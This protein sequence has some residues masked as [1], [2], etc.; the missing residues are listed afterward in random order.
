MCRSLILKGVIF[1]LYHII[2]FIIFWVLFF[3]QKVLYGYILDNF[4]M[5]FRNDKSIYIPLVSFIICFVISIKFFNYYSLKNSVDDEIKE[6]EKEER[7]TNNPVNKHS[8]YYKFKIFFKW[9]LIVAI[10]L[11]VLIFLFVKSNLNEIKDLNKNVRETVIKNEINK[12]SIN[13]E[14]IK[15]KF[16]QKTTGNF[17]M[18]FD[19][20]SISKENGKLTY[21]VLTDFENN[22]KKGT[23]SILS[24]EEI[25]CNS[26]RLDYRSLKEFNF[27]K[28]MGKGKILQTFSEPSEWSFYVAEDSEGYKHLKTI[29]SQ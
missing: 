3:V 25:N 8:F 23:K 10:G 4:E 28:T 27:S 12:P 21:W 16:I 29:C 1:I 11:A 19:K 9:V 26:K 14:N 6:I 2:N 5:S 7:E 13:L 22:E 15:W 20:N 17:S 24:L 18:Y